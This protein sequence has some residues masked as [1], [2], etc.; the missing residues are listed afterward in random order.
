MKKLNYYLLS[1]VLLISLST[2]ALNLTFNSLYE[3]YSLAND[4]VVPVNTQKSTVEWKANKVTGSHEGLINIKTANL[5]F[6]NDLL[7]G[8]EVTIDMSSINCTD[9]SGPYKNKL[10]DHLNS[11]DFFNVSDY[12]SSTLVIKEC[13]KVNEN[14]YNVFADLTI[15]NITESIEFVAELSNNVATA[16]LDIDRTKFDIKYGSGSF[17][18]NLGDKMID[19]NFNLRV[20]INY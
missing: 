5:T 12:P 13:S 11:S 6:D 3:G 16:F 17:F 9:L 1:S 18:E 4:E 10:E 19:D 7:T 15:K 8:G 20:N 2:L 14:K